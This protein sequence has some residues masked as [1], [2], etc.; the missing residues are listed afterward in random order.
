LGDSASI[1]HTVFETVPIC[2]AQT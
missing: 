1:D 2:T